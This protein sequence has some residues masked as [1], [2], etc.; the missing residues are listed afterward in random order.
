M[1][2][3]PRKRWGQHFLHDR[4][5]IDRLLGA[6]AAQ[7]DDQI[8]EIGPGEGVL[9]VPLLAA[10]G[11]V[12]VIEIDRDLA[13][14]L[15]TLPDAQ[16]R[17]RIHVGDALSFDVA[18]LARTNRLRIVG[19]L[20][21]NI[22]TPLLFHLLAQRAAIA[23]MHLMLQREVVDRL[24]APPGSPQRGRLS[25]MVQAY[26]RV[27]ALFRL[28]AGAFRPP[29]KVE[30]AVVRLQPHATPA[31][32]RRTEN[33]FAQ[34]VRLAFAGRRKTLRRTLAPLLDRQAIADCG[35]DPGERPERL[36]VAAFAALANAVAGP[37]DE[38]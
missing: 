8:V 20:P 22:S 28:A 5:A 16:D 34:V 13:A 9:T 14:G 1:S 17:L 31:V 37:G 24:A 30:S 18:G 11:R 12:D 4:H 32:D 36:T 7:A 2:H 38:V 35:V 21:Y 25:V 23:D 27:D 26:C 6:I 33:P 15:A 19:N 3:R 10:A 29:P